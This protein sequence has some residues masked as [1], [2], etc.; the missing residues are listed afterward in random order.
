MPALLLLEAMGNTGEYVIDAALDLGAEVIVATH[1]DVFEEWYSPSLQAKIRDHAKLVFTDFSDAEGALRQLAEVSRAEGVGGVVA[2]WEFLT[3]LVARLSADLGLP[4]NDPSRALGCRNKRIMARAFAEQGVPAP[5]TVAARTLEEAY[6]LVEKAGLGYP[7]VVKPAEQSGSWGVSVVRDDEE[8]EAAFAVVRS[9]LF[10]MPHGIP[11]DAHVVIQEY[12]GGV[13]YSI[14]TV[15]AAGRLTPLFPYDKFT[16][17]G[18]KRAEFGHTVPAELDE[19]SVRVLQEA[20]VEAARALGVRNGVAHTELKLLPDGTTRVIEL[21]ARLPGDHVVALMRRAKGIDEARIYVQVALGLAPDL[22]PTADR[23]A[24]IRFLVPP[25]GGV[26]RSVSGIG[27]SAA[28]A[29]S[30]ITVPPGGRVR[31]PGDNDARVGYVILHA[32][33]APEVNR[34]AAEAIADVTIE[35]E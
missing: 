15:A 14:E 20:A 22:T 23:A 25:R 26:L 29:R 18:A 6:A 16:T 9:H 17:D 31:A 13:E 7:L 2:C 33:T 35:V 24:G 32:D 11:L 8:L 12:V 10:Q 34:A 30:S 3:P 28:V 1:E 27:D 4:G 21:G 19:A 5:R